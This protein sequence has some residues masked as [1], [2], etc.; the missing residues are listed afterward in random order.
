MVGHAMVLEK[1]VATSFVAGHELRPAF[2]VRESAR[3]AAV[4]RL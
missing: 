1:A 4:C 2:E 3:R